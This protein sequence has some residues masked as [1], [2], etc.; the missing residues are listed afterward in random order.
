MLTK[1]YLKDDD[2]DL[3]RITITEEKKTH[4]SFT[5]HEVIAWTAENKPDDFELYL[6]GTIKW[7][8][9]SHV[10][11]GNNQEEPDGYQ[12]LCGKMYWK[13]H[14]AV[15]EWIYKTIFPRIKMADET[16]VW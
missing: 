13:R 5:V 15:M 8:G 3:F 4:I 12:H 14:C 2:Y 7:D 11:F 10:W 9:C 6:H 1:L 16:E